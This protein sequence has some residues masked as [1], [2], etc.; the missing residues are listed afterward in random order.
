MNDSPPPGPRR[1]RSNS[2]SA[3]SISEG[4]PPPRSPTI[5]RSSLTLSPTASTPAPFDFCDRD[6]F[7]PKAAA[8]ATRAYRR[9]SSGPKRL[10]PDL[11]DGEEDVV[12]PARAD[13]YEELVTDSDEDDPPRQA[14]GTSAPLVDTSGSVEEMEIEH[15]EPEPVLRALV[16]AQSSHKPRDPKRTVSFDQPEASTAPEPTGM[17]PPPTN[18]VH[19]HP[20]PRPSQPHSSRPPHWTENPR[21]RDPNLIPPGRQP[22]AQRGWVP[23]P[24]PSS[25]GVGGPKRLDQLVTYLNPSSHRPQQAGQLPPLE[26]SQWVP[27][28][29]G[30]GSPTGMGPDMGFAI[31]MGMGMGMGTG[32]PMMSPP[33]FMPQ[34]GFFGGMGE[35]PMVWYNEHGV[36]LSPEDLAMAAQDVGSMSPPVQDGG[37]TP[38][39]RT[40]SIRPC[41][42]MTPRHTHAPART[43]TGRVATLDGC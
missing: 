22:G 19:D 40:P 17:S 21:S 3:P 9:P 37:R 15:E 43:S 29:N 32:F 6:R 31:Q 13:S 8:D 34:A 14:A 30:M 23:Q 36:V 5:S 24:P 7:A 27:G 33:A 16:L 20:N 18:P 1:S 35:V 42:G 41:G 28:M 12:R 4:P 39:G 38:G 10:V 26:Q 25:A 11:S 2:S